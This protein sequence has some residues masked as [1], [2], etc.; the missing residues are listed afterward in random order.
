[1]KKLYSFLFCVISLLSSA[2]QNLFQK[3]IN[4]NQLNSKQKLN[5]L[6][7]KNYYSTFYFTE[8]IESLEQNFNL[9]L[10]NGKNIAA[11][12]QKKF[13]YP[14]KSSSAIYQIAN[15]PNAE[16]VLS[17][18]NKIITGMYVSQQGDKIIFQE[19]APNIFA[20]SLVDEQML[21]NQDKADD[22]VV[23][24]Q[25]PFSS[26][27]ALAHPT[28][29]SGSVCPNSTIDVMVLYT[30]D[31]KTAYGG[32]SQSNSFIATA[33]TNF[34]TALQNAGVNNVTINLVH[35]G[36]INYVESGNINTDLTR[37]RT[38]GDGFMDDA[39]SLRTLYG[40]DIVALITSTPTNTCG[41]GNLNTNPTNYSAAAAYS[42]TIFSCV[43]SNYSLSHEMGHNMG[44]NHDWYVNTSNN[45]CSHHHGYINRT[46]ITEGTSSPTTA[47][48]RTIMAY[49]NECS[50]LGFNCS[51]RNLWSNPSVNYN[52]EPTGIPIGEANPSNEAYG[53]SRFACVVS[54][55]METAILSAKNTTIEDFGIYPNPVKDQLNINISKNGKYTY[56]I[57]N[58][59]GQKLATTKNT[60]I[61]VKGY[62]SGLYY[63]TVYDED[64]KLIGTKKFVVE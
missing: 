17:E 52:A 31:A 50:E 35:A 36:E 58:A 26:Q 3:P 60:S 42:V 5:S 45:P 9:H 37:F 23:S 57:M 2:Q 10:P 13:Q 63:L 51:R 1:M 40:A 62:T 59:A 53:F 25:E 29:C 64:Q 43:V 7:S 19:V 38:P 47:R 22:T 20:V 39:Q 4:E 41:L 48:W 8:N 27:K 12:F 34:N 14:N 28:V 30:P 61:T 33:I 24:P 46:A 6:M 49:N 55:F 32:T 11:V 15:E 18:Y 56:T 44:L 16:F 54:E 21:I